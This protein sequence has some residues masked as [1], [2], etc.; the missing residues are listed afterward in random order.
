MFKVNIQDTIKVQIEGRLVSLLITFNVLCALIYFRPMLSFYSA[1]RSVMF[2]GGINKEQWP[3]MGQ[4]SAP[5]L[6]FKLIF[7]KHLNPLTPGVH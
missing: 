3:K 1:F 5:L 2:S 6:D 4:S 7:F